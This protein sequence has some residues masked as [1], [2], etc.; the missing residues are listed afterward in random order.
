MEAMSLYAVAFKLLLSL[1]I[2]I[3]FGIERDLKGLQEGEKEDEA[4]FGG[5]RTFALIG[6]L[7]GI[8]AYIGILIS[9][10]VYIY[11]FIAVVL[12]VAVSYIIEH[13]RGG[14]LG[15]TTEFSTL[16]TYSLGA[17]CLIGPIQIVIA[18]TIILLFLLSQKKTIRRWGSRI[19]PAEL[20]ASLKFALV[21]LV[22]FPFLKSVEPFVWQGITIIDPFKIWKMVVLISSVSYLGYFLTRMVGEEK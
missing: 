22:I 3:L 19:K 2:G 5:V 6:L 4:H 8:C 10:P 9:H 11:G 13:R 16:L 12:F 1:V 18:A 20:L 15:M 17:L 21:L 14:K 7:G